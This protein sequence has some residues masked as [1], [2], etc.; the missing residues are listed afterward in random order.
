MFIPSINDIWG[1]LRYF[2]SGLPLK[3]RDFVLC[4]GLGLFGNIGIVE[5]SSVTAQNVSRIFIY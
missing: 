3:L 2:S 4:M 1:R 5:G